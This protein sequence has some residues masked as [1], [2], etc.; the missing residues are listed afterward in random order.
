MDAEAYAVIIAQVAGALGS[1]V[2]VRY[3]EVGG[4]DVDVPDALSRCPLERPLDRELIAEVD[5]ELRWHG[6]G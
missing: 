3:L 1:R 5:S 4:P 2:V 6:I